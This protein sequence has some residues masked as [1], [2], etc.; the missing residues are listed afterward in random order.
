MA[1]L[2]VDGATMWL[3]DRM[4]LNPTTLSKFW[5]ALEED[6][7]DIRPDAVVTLPEGV[8]WLG[9]ELLGSCVYW[10]TM[11]D[12]KKNLPHVVILGN[13]G[14]GKMFFGLFLL[15]HLAR[16]GKTVVYQ[17]R[18]KCILFS[19]TMVI[20]GSEQAFVEIL[21]KTTTYYIVDGAKPP[22]C[23]AKTILLARPQLANWYQFAETNCTIHS[24]EEILTCRALVYPQLP[25]IDVSSCLHRWGGIPRYVLHYARVHC[26]QR[27]L[28]KAINR[29]DWNWMVTAARN[30]DYDEY[31]VWYPLFH[32]RVNKSFE[33][34]GFG[35]ASLYVQ[36]KIY[37]QLYKQNKARLLER[38]ASPITHFGWGGV[39]WDQLLEEHL[40]TLLARVGNFRARR[41]VDDNE[42]YDDDETFA[43]A[44]WDDEGN[45]REHTAEEQE[46]EE[47]VQ[48]EIQ[49]QLTFSTREEVSTAEANTFLRPATKYVADAIVKPRLLF[50]VPGVHKTPLKQSH[51]HDLLELLGN[52]DQPRLYFVLPPSQFHD[53]RYQRYI[54]G[55]DKRIAISSYQN[56]RK[57][58]QFA[59]KVELTS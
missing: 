42:E 21:G 36:R 2:H 47:S 15:L 56:V 53:F 43:E 38:F 26:Q 16:A 19:R 18:D 13:A 44:D 41:L 23:A 32:C 3:T 31:E 17:D 40:L 48:L 58:Q 45:K 46:V 9:D 8:H 39:H 50:Y 34:A 20:R 7:T 37:A 10:E 52:P 14:I 1:N 29:V 30:L 5:R 49:N 12:K 33:G 57:L 51:L 25:L 6:Q 11:H 28:E 55:N 27:W 35:F 54:D 22:Y 24:H 4:T 59:L